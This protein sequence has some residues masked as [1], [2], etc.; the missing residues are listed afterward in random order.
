MA[1][2]RV[3]PPVV[4]IVAAFSRYPDALQ[5]ATEQLQ[6]KFG[7]ILAVSDPFDFDHTDYYTATMGKNLRKQ[8]LA[9]EN[10][11]LPESLPDIKLLTN[12]LEK[13]L[14]QSGRYPEPRP[15]NLDP[16]YLDAG[17]FILATTKDHAHRIYLR[18]GIFAE[19]TLYYEGKQFRPWPWTYRDYRQPLVLDFLEKVRTWYRRRLH[20]S[21]ANS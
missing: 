1:Q 2:P 8:L 19:V 21:A 14:A 15:V 6:E 11:I 20:E 18:Q 13:T 9:F 10:L 16:G 17:K 7:P 5:W 4:L 3:H 12:G